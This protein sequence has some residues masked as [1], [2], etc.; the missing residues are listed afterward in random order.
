MD[1]NMINAQV[2]SV[3]KQA[4][5]AG[6]GSAQ[7]ADG[8]GTAIGWYQAGG[9]FGTCEGS[10]VLVNALVAPRGIEGALTWIGTAEE[11]KFVDSLVGTVTSGSNQSTACGDCK[12]IETNG[13]TLFYP[14]GR[15]CA[16]TPEEQFDRLGL[17][18]QENVPI[19]TLFGNITDPAGG[20]LVP[21]GGVIT[22]RFYIDIRMVGYLARSLLGDMIWQGDTANNSG[23][24]MEFNGLETIVN[25]GKVDVLKGITAPQLNSFLLPNAGNAWT[26]DGTYG[27][28]ARFARVVMQLEQRASGA[29]LD[30]T[31]AEMVIVMSP[32]QWETI[33]RVYACDGIDLCSPALTGSNG[34]IR[35]TTSATEQRNRYEEILRRHALP[36]LGNWYPV[37]VDNMLPE[38]DNGDGTWSSDVYFLTLRIQGQEVLWGEYQDFNRTFGRAAGELASMFGA[39]NSDIAITDGGRYALLKSQVRGCFDVQMILKPRLVSSATFLQARITDAVASPVGAVGLPNP[40]DNVGGRTA[41]NL[42][43]LYQDTGTGVP[44]WFNPNV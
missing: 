3:V 4:L 11:K 17:R 24:Y 32:N 31:T 18:E 42:E 35:V 22:D 38:T 15:F 20:I 10:P 14:L 36:I 25:T 9:L 43:Y 7:K 5:L 37:I 40:D 1:E 33:A 26:S 23:P 41:A 21:Q 28:R 27:V 29:G 8:T 16:Q 6:L 39:Q 13:A 19:K 2:A 44:D 30:W 12:T 34:N